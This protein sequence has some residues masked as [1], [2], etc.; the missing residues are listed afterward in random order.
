MSTRLDNGKGLFLQ[1]P[2]RIISLL[3]L[4]LKIVKVYTNLLYKHNLDGFS[5]IVT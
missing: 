3:S 1:G 2:F 5:S 4:T